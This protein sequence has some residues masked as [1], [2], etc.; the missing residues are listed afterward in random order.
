[1]NL[2]RTAM[3]VA[4][5]GIV[6]LAF[7]FWGTQTA[8][9]RHTFDEMD[10]IIPVAVGTAGAFLLLTAAYLDYRAEKRDKAARDA[11]QKTDDARGEEAGG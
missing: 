9:G 3:L 5:I 11:S 1:M 4:G 6:M 7:G 10:G 8:S 2:R